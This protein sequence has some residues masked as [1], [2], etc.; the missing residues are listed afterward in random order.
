[1]CSVVL[2][3]LDER[4]VSEHQS[5]IKAAVAELLEDEDFKLAITN[6][7]NA[8]KRVTTRF[9]KMESKIAEATR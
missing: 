1:V 5:A 4:T 3:T 9:E 6:A 7:T 8:E 2:S